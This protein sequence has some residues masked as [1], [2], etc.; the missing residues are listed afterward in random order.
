MR[1]IL[2]VILVLQCISSMA[3]SKSIDRFRVNR[4][5]LSNLFFYS[6]T[7]KMLNTENNP[8]LAEMLG[9]IEEIK[10]LNYDRDSQKITREEMNTLK[11]GLE[12][13]SYNVLLSMK[14]K[15]LLLTLY[16]RDRK[17]KTVGMVA[18]MEEG[19]KLVLVDLQGAV[20]VKKFMQLKQKIDMQK[21]PGQENTPQNQ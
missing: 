7:L 2:S 11:S 5:E 16:G 10:V 12:S 4:K 8:E 20:D 6:S 1:I 15:G 19:S 9:G 21:S 3:Q 14:E 13:E 17:G 18:I